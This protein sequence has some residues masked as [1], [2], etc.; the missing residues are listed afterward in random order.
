MHIQIELDIQT[1]P[2][3]ENAIRPSH[4]RLLKSEFVFLED[5]SGRNWRWPL[6]PCATHC[7][8]NAL[9]PFTPLHMYSIH[10]DM[11]VCVCVHSF[12]HLCITISLFM[13]L[14][15]QLVRRIDKRCIYLDMHIQ[16]ELDILT[17]PALENAIR[18]SHGWLLKSEFVFQEDS[19]GA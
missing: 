16:I 14:C 11:C 7:Q 17:H 3:L 9:T 19:P 2:A 4:G 18:P 15:S 6:M 10:L 1:H 8:N 12:F 5:S 13:F